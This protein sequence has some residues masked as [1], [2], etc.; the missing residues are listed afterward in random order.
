[1]WPS[2][3]VDI[4]TSDGVEHADVPVLAHDILADVAVLGPIT[5]DAPAVALAGREPKGGNY[6]YTAGF[7]SGGEL[8]V[9]GGHLFRVVEWE[10]AGAT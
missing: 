4:R 9:R 10:A 2:Q 3:R 8:Q 7:P 5:T 6:V 1:M